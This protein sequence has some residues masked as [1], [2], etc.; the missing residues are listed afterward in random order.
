MLTQI[1]FG[2]SLPGSVG[3]F[4]AEFTSFLL[5]EDSIDQNNTNLID[6][7]DIRN[8]CSG[9]DALHPLVQRMF[10]QSA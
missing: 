3:L 2:L 1:S 4:N 7:S 6:E 9:P 10:A 5:P 8:L